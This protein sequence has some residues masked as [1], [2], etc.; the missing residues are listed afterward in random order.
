MPAH[1]PRASFEPIPPDFDLRQLVETN[2]NFQYVDRISVDTIPEQGIDQFEKLVLLH[3]IIGGKPLVVDG[4]EE[5]LDPRIFTEKWL[6][7]NHG[8]KVENARNLTTK[9]DLPLTIGHYLRNMRKLTDQ[10]FEKP[11]NFRDMNRQRVYLKDIDCPPE[12]RDKVR[13]HIPP[14]LFY[15]ND[16][17]GDIGGPG[18]IDEPVFGGVGG[19]GKGIATA[20]DL[21]SSLPLEMRAEN[22]MCY[23]G[24]EGTYTPA[25]REMCA[26]LGHNIMVEAS[27]TFDENGEPVKSG[28]SI[29]FMTESKDRHMVVEYWLSVLGHDI[30]V[31]NHFAQIV[32]WQKAP[33]KTYVVEQR[34][35]DFI[36]I[37]PLA[38]HQVWNRG[39]R[40]IKVAWNRT[41]V[42][43]LEMAFKEALPNARMVCRDEQYKNKAIVYYT[44]LKYSS[45][46]KQARNIANRSPIETQEIYTSKKVRQVQKDFKRLFNLYKEI[47]LSEM[48]TPDTKEH[49]EFLAFDSNVTCA[50]CRGNIFNRFL[51][52]KTCADVLDGPGTDEPY[53]ICMECFVMGR[54][55]GCQSKYKWVEQFKWKEL[56]A[57]YEEW[58]NQIIEMHGGMRQ[59]APLPLAEE[60]TRYPKKTL[61]QI[62][63]EQL[64]LRP[65][66]NI[67]K[68]RPVEE[69]ENSDDEITVNGDGTL[70][71]AIK[72]KPEGWHENHKSCHC[73]L[74][75]HP[76]WMM[77]HCTMCKRGWCYGSLWRA[78]DLMPQTIMEDPNWECPHCLRICNNGACRKDSRQKPYEPKGTVLGHDTKK[79]ADVRSVE[80][81]VDFG[82]SNM[83]WIRDGVDNPHNSK[84][85]RK[86]QEEAERAKQHVEWLED[87]EQFVDDYMT[88]EGIVAD[89]SPT[90]NDSPGIAYDPIDENIDPALGGR[91]VQ[92][93]DI[94]NDASSVLDP[95]LMGGQDMSIYP[96]LDGENSFATS[97]TMIHKKPLHTSFIQGPGNETPISRKR[98]IPTDEEQIK[99]VEPHPKKCKGVD[100]AA[101]VGKPSASKNKATSQWKKE[102]E[103]K[104]LE[105][106]RK[107]G[108]FVQVLAAMK[109]TKK[110]V[111]LKL[112]RSKL[113][114][115]A[116]A[117]MERSIRRRTPLATQ[118]NRKPLQD[119]NTILRSDVKP[120]EKV[121]AVDEVG[122]VKTKVFRYRT[123]QD[124]DFRATRPWEVE[125]PES[126]VRRRNGRVNPQY[127]YIEVDSDEED[128]IIP[129]GH[130]STGATTNGVGKPKKRKEDPNPLTPPEHFKDSMV[131][132]QKRD[133]DR[134]ATMPVA[135]GA[136]QKVQ[137]ATK[138]RPSWASADDIRTNN[139][140]GLHEKTDKENG[141]EE[142]LSNLVSGRPSPNFRRAAKVAHGKRQGK[143]ERKQNCDSDAVR[144]IK[145]VRVTGNKEVNR[146]MTLQATAAILWK[147]AAKDVVED[148][149][150]NVEKYS[151]ST[152]E[153]TKGTHYVETKSTPISS[154]RKPS[155]P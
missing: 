101:E 130:Y 117:E 93:P 154:I 104:R 27:E 24:H 96:D 44:L 85:M 127:E 113:A 14:S 22:L 4:F 33:F 126:V 114:K 94:D 150:G 66:R 40:T 89:A 37:P 36:L 35:G 76:K 23:I 12:W 72:K 144:T 38:P 25:H 129:T 45:L 110:I 79:V 106:A 17:T 78:F 56:V 108:R 6:R 68:P 128:N 82:T 137:K 11:E 100:D 98:T 109:G 58:R 9:E 111:A 134:R 2:E 141:V 74:K 124:E 80:V 95:N 122:G 29:W 60:R 21:M 73:C 119:S 81:L 48:F 75:R 62:C 88:D 87:D 153:K 131:R 97:H 42:E 41:T 54:S 32:A 51:T 86:K 120:P 52:C 1:R 31:E 19:R 148:I 57:R 149:I 90:A 136:H 69:E 147:D 39:T 83:N 112:P 91:G 10:F 47:L 142:N 53:D 5:R 105:E 26:S 18:S 61:G 49:C 84:R 59:K 20:G 34:P 123:E 28:C 30:E 16:S 107:A 102:Q 151:I 92:F 145:I 140:L 115:I 135:T 118:E 146:R 43:T 67:K 8:D 46:L 63:Q 7:D 55:C 155:I 65:W 13:E 99:L 70:K 50:Y 3:V 64:K 132:N 133:S 116:A 143:A 139:Q 152:A 125:E 121:E 103:S 77:A 15:W 71:K 138:T